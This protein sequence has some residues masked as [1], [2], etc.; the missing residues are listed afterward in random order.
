MLHK[1]S[2]PWLVLS[3]D[4][5]EFVQGICGCFGGSHW[6]LVVLAEAQGHDTIVDEFKKKLV[7]DSRVVA[8]VLPEYHGYLCNRHW[9]C[10]SMQ[11]QRA[12]ARARVREEDREGWRAKKSEW[13]KQGKRKRGRVGGVGG[14][15][16]CPPDGKS[17]SKTLEVYVVGLFLLKRG[18]RDLRAVASSSANSFGKC[19]LFALEKEQ[20]QEQEQVQEQY[21]NLHTHTHTHTHIYINEYTH[22][23]FYMY[24]YVCIFEYTH[25]HTH[26][27]IFMKS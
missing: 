22:L 11:R 9:F 13:E 21:M 6:R 14:E 7:N 16:A 12:Q 20:E 26:T 18:K 27:H 4:R 2:V 1:E 17:K 8:A 24:I 19:Q 10:V 15:R 23:C 5:V 25:T 3:H